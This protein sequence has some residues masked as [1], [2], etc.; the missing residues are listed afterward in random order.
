MIDLLLFFLGMITGNGFEWMIHKW[1]LHGMGK[2]RGSFFAHHWEH[3]RECRRG[4]LNGD[5]S[6][7]SLM[8]SLMSKEAIGLL[9]LSIAI[10]P[11]ALI[12]IPYFAGLVVQMLLYFCI[13]RWIH[14]NPEIGGIVFPWHDHHHLLDQNK[15]WCVTYPLFDSIMRTRSIKRRP[16]HESKSG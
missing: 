2:K 15:N 7:V 13:H 9:A 10:S 12:S 14:L 8:G 6:Y 16:K 3:H 11:V 1:V 5:D 4:R